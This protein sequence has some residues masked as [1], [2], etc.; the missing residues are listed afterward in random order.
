M[1]ERMKCDATAELP[2]YDHSDDLIFQ[3]ALSLIDLK[4]VDERTKK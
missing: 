3:L 4:W 2:E 1:T